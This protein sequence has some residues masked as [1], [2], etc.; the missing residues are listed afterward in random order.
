MDPVKP[1]FS[2]Q[3]IVFIGTFILIGVALLVYLYGVKIQDKEYDSAVNHVDSMLSQAASFQEIASENTFSLYTASEQQLAAATKAAT[4]FKESLKALDQSSLVTK[5]PVIKDSYTSMK[6]KLEQY[7]SGA[8]NSIDTFTVVATIKRTCN[9]FLEKIPTI[10]TISAL[11]DSSA[12]CRSE[13]NKHETV[14]LNEFNDSF[15][16]PYRNAVGGT[17]IALNNYY[18]AATSND[19]A[20]Q[21]KSQNDVSANLKAIETLHNE[22]YS[23]TNSSTPKASLEELKSTITK[24]KNTFLR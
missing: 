15:F 4:Q 3:M 14:P 11:D 23:I 13:L 8:S 20:G 18:T 19:K 24:R 22:D 17:V 12:A 5:D 6:T 1:V 21:Q 7:S 2:R 16:V 10:T 9:A